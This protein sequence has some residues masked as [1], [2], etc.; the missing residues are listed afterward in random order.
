MVLKKLQSISA[1]TATQP[2]RR[3]STSKHPRR[4]SSSSLPGSGGGRPTFRR[5]SRDVDGATSASSSSSS[6]GE[7]ETQPPS[8]PLPPNNNAATMEDEASTPAPSRRPSGMDLDSDVPPTPP[9]PMG[10]PP[11]P[12]RRMPRRRSS[13]ASADG[14][15]GF[16]AA[17]AAASLGSSPRPVRQRRRA[18][19]DAAPTALQRSL[20]REDSSGLNSGPTFRPPPSSAEEPPGSDP[21]GNAAGGASRTANPPDIPRRTS[22]SDMEQSARRASIKQIMQDGR[23]SALEKRRS[24]QNLMD[25]RR[26]STIDCGQTQ[27]Y[28]QAKANEA[29]RREGMNR[30]RSSSFG[31][32]EGMSPGN[33]RSNGGDGSLGGGMERRNTDMSLESDDQ[34]AVAVRPFSGGSP[35]A[36][37]SYH[38]QNNAANSGSAAA[39]APAAAAAHANS[40]PPSFGGGAGGDSS[41]QSPT[42]ENYINV[43][44]HTP[45]AEAAIAAAH[46]QTRSEQFAEKHPYSATS[47]RVPAVA[48]RASEAHP[49]NLKDDG[50]GKAGSQ[51]SN[52]EFAR[53]AI[54]TAPPCTHYERNCHIV[55]PCCGATFGCR[56]CHDDCPVL[57][58]LL[59]A[60]TMEGMLHDAEMGTGGGASGGAGG[61]K[62]QRV[63]RTSSMPTSL[64]A[65]LAPAEH[66]NVDRFAI[67]E[68]ICRECFTKQSSKTNVCVNCNVRFGEYHCPICNLWMSN[69]ERPYHCP[70]CG[71]CRV[72]GGE[73]FRHCDDCGMCID[74][75][76]FADH[77]CKV[78]KYMSNCPV[79]QEDLFSSRDASHELPCGHAIHW[80][81][82]RELASRQPVSHKTAETHER[83]KPTWDAMAMGI[84][85]QP[86][87]PELCKVV[88]IKCNDCE[89]VQENRSWHFLGVQC[90]RCESFNTVVERITMMGQ[91][92]HD[93]LLRENPP[94]PAAGGGGG[95]A[96]SAA[97][98]TTQVATGEQRRRRR[99]A[100]LDMPPSGDVPGPPFGEG[101]R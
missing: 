65:S 84:A 20:L 54:E 25:G 33:E 98:G 91:E 99:R 89:V 29:M 16:A 86:V 28:L 11:A 13:L 96:G 15:S 56:I 35:A 87:P 62:Y 46:L 38:A 5:A 58:P 3:A 51:R 6:D 23:L 14:P 8:P 77:N 59:D 88:T 66:H 12:A 44:D 69:E 24:I 63:L 30:R 32:D 85:L 2:K 18:T 75:Q 92:A 68:V 64:N 31:N 95:A 57:P 76:L 7:S 17:A 81:C 50:G 70:D 78:G 22:M 37:A 93:F 90:Q 61:R 42:S 100:T 55:S 52:A 48:A 53:R 43:P 49:F 73:N 4:A 72:G 94:Q 39:E 40:C 26:R 21:T 67:A 9:P 36:W 80:H 97:A 71:F 10:A 41:R 60:R 82:F 19:V 27:P 1:T 34:P 47:T 79:C 45:A 83:M 101:R 74:K